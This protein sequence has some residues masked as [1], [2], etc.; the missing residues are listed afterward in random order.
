VEPSKK[1]LEREWA[2]IRE[3]TGASQCWKP[4]PR[5]IQELNRHLGGWANYFGYGYPA[6][7]FRKIN[8]YVRER[9]TQHLRRRSQ[10]PFRP[11][12]GVTY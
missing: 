8:W 9:L 5:M 11:P 4:L 7:A 3:M 10:R 2:K 12:E 6:K 1:A